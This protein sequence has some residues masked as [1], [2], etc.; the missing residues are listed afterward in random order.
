M[1]LL[2]DIGDFFK[3]SDDSLPRCNEPGVKKGDDCRCPIDG[4]ETTKGS[5]GCGGDD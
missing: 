2:S 5:G 3:P 4:H 1:S